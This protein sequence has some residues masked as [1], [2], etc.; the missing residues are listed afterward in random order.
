MC[1]I[2]KLGALV[3]FGILVPI[4]I[5]LS[6]SYIKLAHSVKLCGKCSYW[7]KPEWAPHSPVV[8]VHCIPKFNVAT[9]ESPT[10]GGCCVCCA[11]IACPEFYCAVVSWLLLG[12]GTDEHE[13]SMHMWKMFMVSN[14][15]KNGWERKENVI[16]KWGP[17]RKGGKVVLN[18]LTSPFF[19]NHYKVCPE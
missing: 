9:L 8:T 14:V 7:D 5:F 12:L 19:H 16:D 4:L 13:T 6:P 17:W 1:T 18:A 3:A 15:E 11:S 2:V 10:L